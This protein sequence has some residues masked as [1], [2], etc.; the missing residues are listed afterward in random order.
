RY[1]EVIQRPWALD[2][3]PEFETKGI[4]RVHPPKRL[5]DY[6]VRV[7]KSGPDG[8]DLGTLLPAEVMVPLA[9]YT[10]WNLRRRDVGAEGMLASLAGSYI[11]FPRTNAEAK[12]SRD[13]RQSVEQRYGTF[14]E[15]Q[16]RFQAGCEELVPKRDLLKEDAERLVA[17]REKV[18]GRFSGP[19]NKKD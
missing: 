7:P 2:Q 3:G 11:P 18:R 4:L 16:K 9:T 8:N 10:G 14:A 15:Y 13:P 19:E 1:P 12:A 6:V 5:G 17:G